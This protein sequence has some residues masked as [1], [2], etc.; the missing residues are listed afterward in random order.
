M[1]RGFLKPYKTYNFRDKD[2]VIDALRTVWEDSGIKS[3]Q[4]LSEI[5]GVS[6]STYGAWWNGKTRRPKH[7]TVVATARAMGKDFVMVDRKVKSHLK[8]V[9]SR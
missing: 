7:A 3:Y 2:P 4:R 5:T 6:A 1:S 9:A 8:V